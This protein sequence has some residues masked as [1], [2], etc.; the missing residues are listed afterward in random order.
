MTKIF[1]LSIQRNFHRK[2][3]STRVDGDCVVVSLQ[4][5]KV[6]CVGSIFSKCI[7]R[8]QCLEELRFEKKG[9]FGDQP[10]SN[11]NGNASSFHKA[12]LV[13]RRR[14]NKVGFDLVRDDLITVLNI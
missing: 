11:C 1:L 2:Q 5:W 9:Q 12:I 8:D 10:F 14:Q 13:S 3:P 7:F 4:K 6:L